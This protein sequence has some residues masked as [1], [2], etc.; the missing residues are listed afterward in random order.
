MSKTNAELLSEVEDA[1]SRILTGG[2]D[3]SLSDKRLINARL[4]TLYKMRDDLT[5]KIAAASATHPARNS[6]II[7]R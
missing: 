6:G 5:T 7:R 4:E 1:I 2:Q 3:V